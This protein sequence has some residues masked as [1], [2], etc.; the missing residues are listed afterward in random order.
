MV[1]R[2]SASDDLLTAD[3]R[4]AIAEIEASTNILKLVTRMTGMR[5]AGIAKFTETEWIVCSAFDPARMGIEAG[6]S[7]VLETTLCSEFSTNPRALF[8][9]EVSKDERYST[10]PV[11][12][13][14][15]IESYAGVPIFLP[16]GQLYGALCALDS[17]AT[18]FDDPNLSETLVLFARL[19][20]C[21]F[22]ANLWD[23]SDKKVAGSCS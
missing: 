9:P 6:D 2:V 3:E 1:S 8:I 5:F 4:R 10:R 18:L 7:L 20:G 21:I 13:Q 12:K 15:A 14:Y 23:A 19:V 16:D 11:V 22:Y 17:K